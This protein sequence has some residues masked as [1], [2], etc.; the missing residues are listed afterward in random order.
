MME[1]SHNEP[2]L[3]GN[4]AVWWNLCG[5]I[6]PPSWLKASY[7]WMIWEWNQYFIPDVRF[8]AL[9]R[10]SAALSWWNKHGTSP[11]SRGVQTWLV[12]DGWRLS[13]AGCQETGDGGGAATLL[14]IR[15]KCLRS[16][17]AAPVWIRIQTLHPHTNKQTAYGHDVRGVHGSGACLRWCDLVFSIS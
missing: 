3:Y 17:M 6:K 4:V 1:Y 15:V 10:R 2:V 11:S 5:P 8:S 7:W 13:G 9:R 16:E 14:C 12:W